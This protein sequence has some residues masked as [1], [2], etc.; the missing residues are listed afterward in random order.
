MKSPRSRQS[1]LGAPHRSGTTA[2][3]KYIP[4]TPQYLSAYRRGWN[5]WGLQVFRSHP[6]VKLRPILQFSGDWEE[7]F[8]E[9]G[10][11]CGAVTGLTAN[12]QK[13]II[14]FIYCAPPCIAKVKDPLAKYYLVLRL[15]L[16]RQ[17][18]MIVA[19]NPSTLIAMARADAYS[20]TPWRCRRGRGSSHSCGAF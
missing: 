16:H 2:A 20:W 7:S 13:R 5:L 11:P 10:I 15:S 4:V 9:A 6:E 19:A 12:M 8:T 17:V 14:R 1:I 18:A 3:R